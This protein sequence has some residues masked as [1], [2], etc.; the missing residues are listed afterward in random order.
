[1][2]MP[3]P[4]ELEDNDALIGG[5]AICKFVNDLLGTNTSVAAIF[6]RLKLG[7]LPAQKVAGSWIGSK[8][9]LRRFYARG[10]GL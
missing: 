8:R 3:N 6:K 2:I 1:M 5:E 7:Q 10:T 9:G 4:A